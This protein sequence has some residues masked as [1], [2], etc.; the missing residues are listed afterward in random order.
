LSNNFHD[1]ENGQ[2]PRRLETLLAF[3]HSLKLQFFNLSLLDTALTHRSY[4]NESGKKARSA[5]NE[6]LEFLGDAVLGQAVASILFAKMREGSEGDLA[7]IKSLVVSEQALASLALSIGIPQALRMGKGEEMSGGRA[8]KALLADAVEALIGALYL[9]QGSD[10]A[11]AFIESLLHDVIQRSI[12]APSKDYKTLIQEYAQKYLKTLPVY[13]LE[14]T[15]GPEH[16]RRFWISCSL[17]K[18]KF[19]PFSGKTKKEAEQKAAE[20]VYSALEATSPEEARRLSFIAGQDLN[21]D[22]ISL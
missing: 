8:K 14:K 11:Q 18:K 5:H 9:D 17:D 6:R 20:G 2:D 10:I 4:V 1:V 15:E 7:R 21:V 19:G 3:Q 12:E 22:R 16:E 13:N